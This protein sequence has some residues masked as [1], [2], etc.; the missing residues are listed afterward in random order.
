MSQRHLDSLFRPKSI[1]FI[2]ASKEPGRIG[3]MVIQ[4]LLHGGFD[5]P[6]M[7]VTR[8]F[9]S[10]GGVLAYPNVASLPAT[11]ELAII[12]TPPEPVP[13]L[14]DEL[15]KRGTRAAVVLTWG[16]SGVYD[17]RGR[18]ALEAML[19]AARP[20]NLRILGPNSLGLLVPGV[21]LN[22]SFAHRPALPGKI[23]FV[24]QSGGMCTGV[25]DWARARG[26]GFSHFIA[27]GEYVDV[28]FAEVIDY[29]S[30]EPST[31]AIL[32]YMK[33]L[34]HPRRFMSAA[35]AAA[36]NKPL[37]V[38]KA[39]REPAAVGGTPPQVGPLIDSDAVYDA[40]FRRAGM[41]RVSDTDE[42]FA[43]V[44]TLARSGPVGKDDLTIMSNGEGI[45][46]MAVDAL[47]QG[48]G[49][50]AELS[51]ATLNQ[52]DEVIPTVRSRGNPVNIR[53]DAAEERYSRVLR[54]LIAAKEVDTVLVL[55]APTAVASGVAAAEAVAHAASETR[56]NI[57]TCWIGAESA[58]P[59]RKLFA[60][61]GIPSYE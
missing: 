2:G 13:S 49:S 21:G 46:S 25:L 55:H 52:L 16:M 54:V 14:V 34:H 1:A 8:R 56:S 4:N 5:G 15:G 61:A 26:I 44:E 10:V 23:A 45:G 50:L 35:R 27:L 42:L 22:A 48:G 60:K 3:T 43:A 39:A 53:G 7:P 18:T 33:A 17:G 9:K 19:D 57:L 58:A 41:L 59:A 11:P 30:M 51:E 6:I 36:R 40:A 47:I 20:Y 31:Q 38:I 24:S 12:G 32:L 37:L 29:L 28:G